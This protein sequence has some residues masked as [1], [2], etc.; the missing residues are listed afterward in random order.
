MGK[1]QTKTIETLRADLLEAG[2]MIASRDRQ[3]TDQ[4]TERRTLEVDFTEV[5]EE[6]GTLIRKIAALQADVSVL[7]LEADQA[8]ERETLLN[9]ER[10]QWQESTLMAREDLRKCRQH[11]DRLLDERNELSDR[12]FRGVQS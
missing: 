3:I 7:E 11:R 12:L 8:K 10:D 9:G 1:L 5:V 2:R 6:R 4:K